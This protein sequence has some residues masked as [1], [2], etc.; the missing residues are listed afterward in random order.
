MEL[1]FLDV[2]FNFV[3]IKMFVFVVLFVKKKVEFVVEFV[4]VVSFKEKKWVIVGFMSK[5]DRVVFK[6]DDY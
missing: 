1:M 2:D 5:V 4:K 6:I 3:K